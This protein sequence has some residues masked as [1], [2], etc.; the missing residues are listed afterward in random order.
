MH[1]GD[2]ACVVSLIS[3]NTPKEV[4]LQ[5]LKLVAVQ[6]VSGLAPVIKS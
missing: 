4:P 6:P 3:L 1:S 2:S 5:D